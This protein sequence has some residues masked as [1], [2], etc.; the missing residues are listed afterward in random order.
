M[1]NGVAAGGDY[2]SALMPGNLGLVGKVAESWGVAGGLLGAGVASVHMVAGGLSSSLGFLTATILFVAGSLVGFL[3]GGM[4]GY[5]GRPAEVTRKLALRRL[6]LAAFY[7]V[8]AM[9]V[10][11]LFALALALS[12][13]GLAT[14]RPEL[15]VLS[16]IGWLGLVGAVSWAVVETRRALPHL[17]ARWPGA[18]GGLTILV[19]A[20]L[21]LLPFFLIS[22]PEVWVL[23]VTPTETAAVFM[24]VLATLW[25]GG[26]LVSL[27]VLA[28]RAWRRSHPAPDRG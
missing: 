8:P 16:A 20:F 17:C 9:L 7:A 22:R 3:H 21:A 27:G 18:R 6:V 13:S 28:L 15:L 12:A 1:V 5:L 19:L 24:A 14:R 4:L 25:I 10:G 26:P 23:G 2:L 11:W